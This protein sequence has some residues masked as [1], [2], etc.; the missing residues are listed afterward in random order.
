MSAEIAQLEATILALESQRAVLGDLVV[1]TA[2]GPLRARLAALNAP[3]APPPPAA[4]EAAE[5]AQALKLVTVMFLD[6]VGS[7]TLSQHLDP[8]EIHAVMDGALERCTAIVQSHGGKVLQYAGD[9]LLAA[10]G[11]DEA[12]ED[13]AR[14]AVLCGLAL[15]AEG[16]ALGEEVA[17]AHRH[18]GF[19]VRVGLHT[20]GVLLGGGV[21]AEGTI[22]GISVNIAA[23]MEQTAP[24]GALRI[25]HDT[26]RQ[27]RGLF[28]AEEQDPIAVKG[29]D[30]P[31]VTYLVKRAK[32]RAQ[33]TST[34]GVEGVDTRMIGRDAELHALQDAFSRVAA[35]RQLEMVQVV[36]EAGVG[37]SRLL[38]EFDQWAETQRERFHSFQGRADPQTQAQ[39][40]GLLRDVLAWR[41]QIADGDPMPLARQKVE[42]GIAP[43][44]MDDDGPA[45]AQAH[46][47]LLGHLIGLDFS[48]SPHVQGILDDPQQ[49]RARAFH[50]AVQSFRRFSAHGG[51][52][53]V[54]QL[55]DLHWSDDG[56]LDFLAHLCRVNR[57]VPMLLL[58]LTRPTLYE[59]RAD[60]AA[61]PWPLQRIDLAPLDKQGSQQLADELLQKLPEVPAA[62]TELIIGRAEG[63]PFYMEELVKMLVDQGALEPGPER[64]AL[65]AERLVA[66]A[67]PPTLTGVLQARLDGLPGIERLALQEASVIGMVFWAQ[68]LAALDDQAPRALPALARRELALPRADSSLDGAQEYAFKHQILREVTYDTLLKRFRRKFHARAADWLAGQTGARANAL[69]GTA[70]EHYEKAGD[71]AHAAEYYTRA[72]EE[73]R[74]RYAHGAVLANVSRALA[75][76]SDE[77][78][79]SAEAVQSLRWR[80][81]DARERT[82]DLQGRRPEQRADLEVLEQMAEAMGDDH[83]RADLATRRCLLAVRTGD[84]TGQRDAARLAMALATRAQDTKLRLN[85]QRLLADAMAR[86]GDVDGGQALALEGLAEARAS[87]LIGLESRFLNALTVIANRKQDV[88]ALLDACQQAVRLRRELGDRRN[89]AIGMATLGGAWLE[90]GDLEQAQYD[91]DE[92]LKLHRAVGDR[93]LEPIAL[94]N[95]SQLAMWQGQGERARSHAMAALEIAV[96]VQA[97]ELE[98]F[99]C[100]S[101]GQAELALGQA[102]AA[103]QAFGRALAVADAIDSPYRLDAVAGLARVAL[104]R[105]DLPAAQAQVQVLQ[106]HEAGGGQLDGTLGQRLIELTWWQVLV[107]AGDAAAGPLLER[108]HAGLLARAEAINDLSLRE[109]FLARVPENRALLAA[110]AARPPTR[111]DGA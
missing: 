13:D 14:R 55:D 110:W 23:R 20:G 104:A 77:T 76:L 57:D 21:D 74:K 1:D 84:Y 80:L 26:W 85:A 99:A 16:R 28:D 33:R 36:A 65:H 103:A 30:K 45:L 38:H 62:L 35:G 107:R 41:L 58:C 92:C 89:E 8:E 86:L 32:P 106:A 31:I 81:L 67:V 25:S 53:I 6:V 79:L 105:D 48:D 27:V 93:G 61:P 91:L 68:A 98:A 54:L 109:S 96:D 7:T 60:W 82:L 39:P 10:F 70:A 63:N 59:R 83:R 29:V 108:A 51:L 111:P 42:A 18:E 44:F 2:V 66:A 19:N 95:L 11:A 88:V 94:A 4:P 5:P 102:D 71:A 17:R 87:G 50:A 64:W 22:R 75:L 3:P 43:L 100:W 37:K 78:A 34:R 46:A 90:L 49:I 9:N 15:L 73:A 24:A 52:P 56:S 97:K 40:Y 69:L 47:H 101:L 12:R 72:A